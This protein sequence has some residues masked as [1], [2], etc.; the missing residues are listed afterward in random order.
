M[1]WLFL[2]VRCG[3]LVERPNEKELSHRSGSEAAQQL[4]TH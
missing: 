2:I 4:G 3:V 1:V